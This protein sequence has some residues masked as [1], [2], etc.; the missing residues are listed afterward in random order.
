M[1]KKPIKIK[2]MKKSIIV[3]IHLLSEEVISRT[4]HAS[5]S[6]VYKFVFDTIAPVDGGIWLIAGVDYKSNFMKEIVITEEAGI[7]LNALDQKY[8]DLEEAK[9]LEIHQVDSYKRAYELALSIRE[10]KPHKNDTNG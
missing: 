6:D 10:T 2:T 8:W 3:N 1:I 9:S 4:R 5:K 7:V